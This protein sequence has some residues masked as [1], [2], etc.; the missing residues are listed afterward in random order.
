MKGKTPTIQLTSGKTEKSHTD[1]NIFFN[2]IPES[3]IVG[4][5]RPR[6]EANRAVYMQPI[7]V[8]ESKLTN[9]HRLPVSPVVEV[10]GLSTTEHPVV[11]L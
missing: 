3:C 8:A 9:T 2:G 1:V 5:T 4:L 10:T 11:D 6:S 7:D